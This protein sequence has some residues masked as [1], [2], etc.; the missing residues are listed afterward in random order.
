MATCISK[1]LR[2]RK[3]SQR[4]LSGAH[5]YG[6]HHSRDEKPSL[7]YFVGSEICATVHRPPHPPDEHAF[8]LTSELHAELDTLHPLVLC[9]K[10]QPTS[11]SVGRGKIK[12]KVLED[13]NTGDSHTCQVVKVRV[14][15]AD[16]STQV[17]RQDY[18][19]KFYDPLYWNFDQWNTDYFRGADSQYAHEVEA[20]NHLQP[21]QG[22][23]VP[24]FHGA[25]SADIPLPKG[26]ACRAVRF[27]LVEHVSGQ[28]LSKLDTREYS[29][30]QCQALMRAII[31]ADRAIR[32]HDVIHGDMSPRNVMLERPMPQGRNEPKI[33]IIDFDSSTCG[34]L[35]EVGHISSGASG[36]RSPESRD[37]TVELWSHENSEDILIAFKLWI[38]AWDWNVWL[39]SRYRV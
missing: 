16:R 1:N 5:A 18:V 15:T 35:S 17:A 21:L 37:R 22:H 14:L 39:Q 13:I 3:S 4:A 31:N 6:R 12:L 36:R 33:R 8:W 28:P 7:P 24:R 9:L 34:Y 30:R 10:Y 11:G 26:N 38:E 23:L 2:S 32:Q 20:Y 25:F 19:A 27:I 29:S